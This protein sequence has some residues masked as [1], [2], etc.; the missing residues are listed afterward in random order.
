MNNSQFKNFDLRKKPRIGE[1]VI[2][3]L[4]FIAGILS[5]FTT[6]AIVYELGKEAWLFFGSPDVTFA[7]FFGTTEVD[8][9]T[10]FTS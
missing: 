8:N 3:S 5:I 2:Q 4:L 9:N 6:V 10:L 1:D 7:K